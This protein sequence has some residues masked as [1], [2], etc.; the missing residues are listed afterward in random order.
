MAADAHAEPLGAEDGGDHSH[1]SRP[2]WWPAPTRR[3]KAS[4][5]DSPAGAQIAERGGG[6]DAAFVD[7]GDAVAEAL[8]DFEHVGGEKDGGAALHLVEQDVLHEARADGVDA[9]EGLV[10]EEE[11][12]MVDEG[13]GHGDA[14][15]HAFGVFADD[16]AVGLKLKEVHEAAGALDGLRAREG[17]HAADEFEELDAGEAVEEEGLV[18]DEADLLFDFEFAVRG[19]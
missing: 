3:T 7:D 9:F 1:S 19:V 2:V 12:G 10:H 15:A 8:D 5:S 17:V 4:S 11:F 18:G 16:F 6:H 13:G 14:L